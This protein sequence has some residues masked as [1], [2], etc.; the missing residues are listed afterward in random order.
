MIKLFAFIK[1]IKD[2]IDELYT[3][4]M[5]KLVEML[6]LSELELAIANGKVVKF[7]KGRHKKRGLKFK[8]GIK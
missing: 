4:I 6:E 1:H 2:S 8:M 3:R 5:D 7:S